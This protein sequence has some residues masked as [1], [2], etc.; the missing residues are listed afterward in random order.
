MLD[1]DTTT[2]TSTITTTITTVTIRD[3]EI[4]ERGRLEERLDRR[5]PGSSVRCSRR[6]NYVKN[7]WCPQA[8]TRSFLLS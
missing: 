8:T 2:T 6:E 5:G 4:L 1:F 7:V 3:F